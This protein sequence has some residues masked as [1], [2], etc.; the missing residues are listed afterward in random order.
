MKARFDDQLKLAADG[1]KLEACG[2][3]DWD[4]IQSNKV[5]AT[6]TITQAGVAAAGTS[7][8]LD[9]GA[10]EWMVN[11]RP[12]PGQKFQAGQAQANGVLTFTDCPPAG[13]E[14]FPWDGQ[15]DLTFDLSGS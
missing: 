12:Q 8:V 11:L 3:L 10:P 6:V 1:R 7:A 5:T 9:R 14:P 13:E 4:E 2:E 15:P